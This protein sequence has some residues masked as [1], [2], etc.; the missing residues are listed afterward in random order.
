MFLGEELLLQLQYHV[1]AVG[2]PLARVDSSVCVRHRHRAPDSRRN[3]LHHAEFQTK[4]G[5]LA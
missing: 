4:V 1:V 3:G 2:S 5:A